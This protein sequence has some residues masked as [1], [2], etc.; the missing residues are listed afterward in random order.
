MIEV[1][2]I[3][4]AIGN[5]A[6]WTTVVYMYSELEKRGMFVNHKVLRELWAEANEVEGKKMVPVIQPAPSRPVPHDLPPVPPIQNGSVID[7]TPVGAPA[8][9]AASTFAAPLGAQRIRQIVDFC[10][11]HKT[12]TTRQVM[13]EEEDGYDG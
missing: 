4:T 10:L 5:H 11:N 8:I 6:P 2:D 7:A 9:R 3:Y 12:K 13:R 1:D